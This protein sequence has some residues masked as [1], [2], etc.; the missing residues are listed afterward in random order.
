M[1][2]CARMTSFVLEMTKFPQCFQYRPLLD[3]VS[4][5]RNTCLCLPSLFRIIHIVYDIVLERFPFFRNMGL[6]WV[7]LRRASSHGSMHGI[8]QLPRG[9]SLGGFWSRSDPQTRAILGSK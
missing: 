6:P 1:K 4:F 8:S 5:T 9:S 3:V 2:Q 7:Y